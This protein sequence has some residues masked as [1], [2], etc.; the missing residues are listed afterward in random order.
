MGCITG[1]SHIS[2]NTQINHEK[3]IFEDKTKP[4]FPNFNSKEVIIYSEQHKKNYRIINSGIIGRNKNCEI[5]I[6]DESVSKNHLEIIYKEN[7]GFMIKDLGSLNGSYILLEPNFI[8]SL[9]MN[10][11]IQIGGTFY[12]IQV[13]TEDEIN[14]RYHS[15]NDF[16]IRNY[17][18]LILTKKGIENKIKCLNFDDN[19]VNPEENLKHLHIQEYF[20]KN[21]TGEFILT[22]HQ[23]TT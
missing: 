13:L 8:L 3:T 20:E 1:K 11:E 4:I 18:F 15:D 19:Q 6:E 2:K 23:N 7:E 22:N 14:F 17:A 5:S 9:K 21:E 12:Y 16:A 10:M